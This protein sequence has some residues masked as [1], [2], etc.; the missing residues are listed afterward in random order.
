MVYADRNKLFRQSLLKFL[1]VRYLWFFIGLFFY[2]ATQ[3]QAS[4][5]P[6]KPAVNL[7]AALPRVAI[8][9]FKVY[10]QNLPVD[11]LLR[12]HQIELPNDRNTFSISFALVGLPDTLVYYYKLDGADNG[13]TQALKSQTVN[14]TLLPPGS[15][16]FLVRAQN[17][18]GTL[19]T[20]ITKL[21]ILIRIPFWLSWWFILL[22]CLLFT[23]I[24]YYFHRQSVNRILAIEAI[25][26]KVARDLHD[27]MGSTLSTINI[28]SMMAKNKLA[29]DPAK[30]GAFL[31]KISDNSSRMMEAM[32]DIVWSINPANDSMDKIVARMRS[33]ATEVLE[34]KD[35]DLAFTVS[36]DVQSVH[37]D[38]EQRRDF[39]LIYKEAIN[40]IAK[41]AHCKK[42]IITL[43]LT[44]Q[45]LTLSIADDGAGF[46]VA[47][48]DTGNGLNNMRKRAENLGSITIESIPGSG[49]TVCLQIPVT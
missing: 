17:K 11:S 49:T 32:D 42:T 45:K 2:S 18:K 16:T 40:N 39:F 25:R 35:I 46:D 30:A 6:N 28:L 34:A 22:G 31:T 21:P 13:W 37:L 27:D 8:T 38:M 44:Q 23:G 10:N 36:G 26:Q 12:L 29:E 1:H 20:P 24:I 9:D 4:L 3:A 7:G 43:E 33:F 48:A 19:V 15:Y 5:S 47:A 41:Y 14:Y